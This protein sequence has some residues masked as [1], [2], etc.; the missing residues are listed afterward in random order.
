MA[1]RADYHVHLENGPYTPEWLGAFL[2]VARRRGLQELGFSEHLHDFYEGQEAS[3]RWWEEDPDPLERGYAERWWRARPRH[4]LDEYAAFI[5]SAREHS[6]LPLRLGLEVDY[7]PGREEA[8]RRLLAAY[9]LDFTL[10]SVHWLGAWGF[11]HLNRLDRWRGRDVDA[12]FQGY[13]DLLGRAARSGLFDIMAH[14]DLI[15]LAGYRPSYDLKPLY[16]GAAR[17]FAEG[18]VAVE[19]STAGLYRPVGEIY[20]AEPFLRLCREYEVPIVISSD[21]HRPEEVGRDREAA[22]ALARRCG[23]TRVCRFIGRKREEVRL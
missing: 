10:G 18:G 8:L 6:A 5:Q 2:Q 12:A 1:F 13:F 20:P 9:P 19:V 23:Y 15:K 14:P 16:E 4:R 11:D 7:F 3:G 22:V 17:A 21:A